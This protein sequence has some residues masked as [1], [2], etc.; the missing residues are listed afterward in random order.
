MELRRSVPKIAGRHRTVPVAETWERIRPHLRRAG[1]T[2]L[3]DITGLDRVGVPVYSAVAPRSGDL[4]HGKG[5]TRL[6]ARTSAAMEAIERFSAVLPMRPAM[7]AS[8]AEL[9]AEGRAAFD[10]RDHSWTLAPGYT[11]DWPISWVEGWELISATTVLVPYAAAGFHTAPHEPSPFRIT[12]TNGLASG[13]SLEEAIVHALCEIVERDASTLAGLVGG[14]LAAAM[15]DASTRLDH[16]RLVDP[17]AVSPLAG[18]T[19]ER[20]AGAGVRLRLLDIT[21]DLG[22]PTFLAVAAGDE[23]RASGAGTHPDAGTAALRAITECAQGRAARFQG[24]RDDLGEDDPAGW[25]WDITSPTVPPPTSYPSD[26]L[27]ADLSFLLDRV[28]DRGLGRAIVVDLSPP[29]IPAHVV[30]V[31]V[32]GTESWHIDRSKLGL[33]GAAAWNDAVRRTAGPTS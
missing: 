11:D 22:V 6:D 21:S 5:L 29:G 18:A 26:D 1:V 31:L 17:G 7:V 10:P 25:V 4:Y 32:P 30:R 8:Y 27:A 23:S 24:L 12:T 16:H 33:R 15:G 13:N 20:F 2:R 28:R 3:A 14:A 9:I 19:A